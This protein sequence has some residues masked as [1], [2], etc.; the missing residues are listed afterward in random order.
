MMRLLKGM[1][2]RSRRIRIKGGRRKQGRRR[3]LLK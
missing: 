1:K 2:K 3:Q